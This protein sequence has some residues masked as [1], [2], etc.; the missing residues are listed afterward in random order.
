MLS[1]SEWNDGQEGDRSLEESQK[2]KVKVQ[3]SK[4]K[5]EPKP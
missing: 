1:F 3:K 4:V 5:E 2:A